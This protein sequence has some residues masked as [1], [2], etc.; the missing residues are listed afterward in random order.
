MWRHFKDGVLEACDE[1][2]GK[3]SKGD[4]W[5]LN[6]E[7]VEAILRKK[8]AHK[9]LCRNGTEKNK[10]RYESMKNKAKKAFS[11]TMREKAG[12]AIA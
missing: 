2:C 1:V 10:R 3:R 8:D 12:D 9:V 6:D 5:W 11:K 4:I 7:I